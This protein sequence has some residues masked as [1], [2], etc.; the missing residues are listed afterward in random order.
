VR[1]ARTL[2]AKAGKNKNKQKT[3]ASFFCKKKQEHGEADTAKQGPEQ[4]S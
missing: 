4:S 3:L 2:A 1:A